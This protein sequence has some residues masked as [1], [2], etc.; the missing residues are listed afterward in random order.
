MIKLPLY[1]FDL[2][3][4]LALIDHRR[5]LLLE[6]R[7]DEFYEACDKDLP[8][9][10]IIDIYQRIRNTGA[11]IWIW[12][13]RSEVVRQKTIRWLCEHLEDDKF[14]NGDYTLVMRPA[15]DNTPDH[16]LKY[17][18]YKQMYPE[19]QARLMAVFDDRQRLVDMWRSI[20]VTCLQ[21]AK[22]DF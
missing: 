16:Q 11:E 15:K 12:S 5:P 3:G 7:W 9:K 4:T 6:N 1:I 17:S 22:G 21:V 13:G 14:A 19:N 8:N 20:G 18:W 10:P 2:D